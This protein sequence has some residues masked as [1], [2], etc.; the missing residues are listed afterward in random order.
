MV[1]VAV[2]QMVA[3][4]FMVRA[5]S[6]VRWW[7]R[8]PSAL[9]CTAPG[10]AVPLGGGSFRTAGEGRSGGG[11]PPQAYGRICNSDG[12]VVVGRPPRLRAG[13]T[14]SEGGGGHAAGKSRHFHPAEH[15]IEISCV[16]TMELVVLA[17]RDGTGR[18]P[19]AEPLAINSTSLDPPWLLWPKT[20]H[21]PKHADQERP[22]S[23]WQHALARRPRTAV[24]WLGA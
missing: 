17:L 23:S 4:S 2:G 16:I 15:R 7:R 3:V 9:S 21:S 5:L 24:P 20:L 6:A 8:A 13:L 18:R 12:I 19:C 10:G 14:V 22:A 11:V 1:L